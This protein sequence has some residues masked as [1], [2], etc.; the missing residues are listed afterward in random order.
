[1]LSVVKTGAKLLPNGIVDSVWPDVRIKSSPNFPKIAQKV[2]TAV[3]TEKVLFFKIAKSHLIYKAS[4]ERKFIKK[5][6]QKSSNCNTA[7]TH[8]VL[9]G[10]NIIDDGYR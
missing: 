4:F 9:L 2:V 1:M 7:T 5:N 10:S 3:L 6:F 8:T